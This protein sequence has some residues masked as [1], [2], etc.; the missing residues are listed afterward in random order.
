MRYVTIEQG[1][2]VSKLPIWETC[3]ECGEKEDFCFASSFQ[4]TCDL[5]MALSKKRRD[6]VTLRAYIASLEKRL[7]RKR[8]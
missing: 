4:P 6:G 2:Y 7:S 8:K 1:G 3:V 5:C